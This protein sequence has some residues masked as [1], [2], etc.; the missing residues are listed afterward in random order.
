M[1]IGLFYGL[2]KN[3]NQPSSLILIVLARA[4]EK[5]TSKLGQQQT[6]FPQPQMPPSGRQK[7]QRGSLGPRNLADLRAT[8]LP[9]K[10]AATTLKS[11]HW[12]MFV[13]T[14]FKDS[15]KMHGAQ[16]CEQLVVKRRMK[17]CTKTP[18]TSVTV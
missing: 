10:W 16:M 12:C 17:I 14:I 7:S 5:T 9:C 11:H 8:P 3:T 18:T 4:I 15:D 1:C 13:W 2:Q 6:S